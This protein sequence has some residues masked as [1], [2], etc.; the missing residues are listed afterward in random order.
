MDI[1]W[2]E[3]ITNTVRNHMVQVCQSEA[4][5]AEI[6]THYIKEGLLNN[7]AV[8]IIARPALRKTVLSK[9]DALGLNVHVFRSQGQVKFFD[10]GFLLSNIL[11]DGV[12]DEHSF[13][14]FIG[15]PI[16]VAQ[17]NHGKVFAFGEMVD[18]LWQRGLHDTAMQ[19]EGLWGGLFEKQELT[20]LC[21]Y[22]LDSLDS[23]TYGN[24]LER[25]CKCHTQWL[26]INVFNP[27][28]GGEKMLEIFGTAWDSVIGELTETK[29]IPKQLPEASI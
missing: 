14:R 11:I 2:V 6:V 5:Q 12:I 15:I 23:A 22:L 20:L 27:V 26:P 16:E 1:H 24:A 21:T 29:N 8:I 25:I 18:I 4:S 9:L 19:L 3:P 13:H 28:V 17:S 7:A 10:A